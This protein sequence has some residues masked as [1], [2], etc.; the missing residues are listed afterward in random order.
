MRRSL[1]SRRAG[2][3][4]RVRLFA[5]QITISRGMP[6]DRNGSASHSQLTGGNLGFEPALD[7]LHRA[8]QWPEL[9]LSRRC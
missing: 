8:L 2:E 1:R 6:W 3:A 4:N 9:A 5:A 7:N